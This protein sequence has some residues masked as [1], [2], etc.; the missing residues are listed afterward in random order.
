MGE[1]IQILIIEGDAALAEALGLLLER[2]GYQVHH[3]VRASEGLE[4]AREMQPDLLLVDGAF[5]SLLAQLCADPSL[6]KVPV[7][8]LAGMGEGPPPFCPPLHAVLEKPCKPHQVLAGIEGLLALHAPPGEAPSATILVVDDDPDFSQIV[9]RV[10]RANGY[11]VR[12]AASGREAW[13]Q[14]QEATPDLVLLDIMMSTVLDGLG[15]SQRMRDDPALRH[16]PVV[17]VSSIA[18]TEYAAAFPTDQALHMDA[19]LSKPVDPETLLRMIRLHLPSTGE[20]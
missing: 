14:M 17:M 7:L 20:I 11:Q 12:T 5:G 6:Q 18:D 19:W 4:L 13:R 9:T 2:A 8:L 1:Q 16:V 10:L 3:T 15:V